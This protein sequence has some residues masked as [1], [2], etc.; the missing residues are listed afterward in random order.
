VVLISPATAQ[1]LGLSD[2]S[3]EAASIEDCLNRNTG[4]TD[5]LR[6]SGLPTRLM[7]RIKAW[8]MGG[9]AEVAAE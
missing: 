3:A 7:G 1:M 2:L 9:V 8:T 5:M 6:L 4:M